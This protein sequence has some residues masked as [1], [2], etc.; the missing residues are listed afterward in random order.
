MWLKI[1]YGR[2]DDFQV[3]V[4]A[5]FC[6][7]H[8]YRHMYFCFWLRNLRRGDRSVVTQ[9]PFLFSALSSLF[10]VL[11]V[12]SYYQGLPSCIVALLYRVLVSPDNLVFY[13][14]FV[15]ESFLVTTIGQRNNIALQLF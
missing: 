6:V 12:H 10:I 5:F 7:G 1:L 8:F 4:S 2:M 3:Y 14:L 11:V 9:T 13:K 15:E